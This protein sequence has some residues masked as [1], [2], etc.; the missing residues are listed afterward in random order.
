MKEAIDINTLKIAV[1]GAGT[2]GTA[3]ADLLGSKGFQIDLWAFE[4]E[5]KQGIIT[6]RVNPYFLP[7]IRLSDNV[8]PSNDLMEVVSGKDLLVIVVPSHVMR[9]MAEEMSHAVAPETLIVSASKGI[10]NNTHLTMSGVL[11][12]TLSQIQEEN[13]AVISGPSFARE[14]ANRTPTAVTVAA[15]ATG[16]SR[17]VQ[18]VFATPYFRVYTTDDIIGVELGGAVKN[19]IAIATGIIDGLE[20]GLNARAALIARGLTEISRLGL[21][22]GANPQTFA[23]LAGIGDLVLTC[24]GDLSRNHSVGKQI[25]AGKSIS[26]VL[27]DMR[28]VAEGVKTAK[29]VYNL[30]RKLNVDMPIC[31]ETFHILYDNL[32]PREAVHRLMARDLKRERDEW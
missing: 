29:S 15:K 18:H 4:E 2:W 30:S 31:E 11:K 13:V 24:T 23:G 5:V 7:E 12:E 14:V 9:K 26:E 8:H 28:M 21:K 19:V 27:S 22:L 32:P 10:E 25:G 6:N 1:V 16:Y 17:L 20:L 3:L